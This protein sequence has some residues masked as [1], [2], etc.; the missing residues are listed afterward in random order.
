MSSAAVKKTLSSFH[1]QFDREKSQ[2]DLIAKLGRRKIE[3]GDKITAPFG[4]LIS[5]GEFM[6]QV[7]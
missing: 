4:K 5:S 7:T 2:D 6:N 1:A 3:F